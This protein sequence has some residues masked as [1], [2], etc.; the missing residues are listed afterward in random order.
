MPPG[1]ARETAVAIRGWT[2]S[3][4]STPL[5]TRAALSRSVASAASSGPNPA[6][7]AASSGEISVP[8]TAQA[9][10]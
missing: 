5:S 4:E 3:S 8:S 2:N 6:T 1:M 10:A 9:Q 7:F